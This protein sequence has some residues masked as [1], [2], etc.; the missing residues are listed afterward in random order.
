MSEAAGRK[1]RQEDWGQENSSVLNSFISS[2]CSGVQ[3]IQQELTENGGEAP[4]PFPQSC[5]DD[6][7]IENRALFK[8]SGIP[9]GMICLSTRRWKGWWKNLVVRPRPHRIPEWLTH[10]HESTSP[11]NRVDRFQIIPTGFRNVLG[12]ARVAINR[13]PLT[14]FVEGQIAEFRAMVVIIDVGSKGES[15]DGLPIS[16][17]GWPCHGIPGRAPFKSR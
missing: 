3:T 9:L 1:S 17:G 6:L 4:S 14:G 5:K 11:K 8:K 12:G 16:H 13:K 10:I 15:H 2:L 7:S